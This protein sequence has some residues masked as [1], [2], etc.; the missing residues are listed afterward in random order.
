MYHLY[1]LIYNLLCY[2]IFSFSTVCSSSTNNTPDSPPSHTTYSPHI[3]NPRLHPH[4]IQQQTPLIPHHP[5]HP[6]QQQQLQQQQHHMLQQQQQHIL[7]YHRGQDFQQGNLFRKFA[8]PVGDIC[9]RG[10]YFRFWIEIDNIV[11]Y[12]IFAIK[13][14]LKNIEPISNI[15]FM[16]NLKR[17]LTFL[18]STRNYFLPFKKKS[19]LFWGFNLNRKVKTV[20]MPNEVAT[21]ALLAKQVF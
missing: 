5:H 2:C 13:M 16:M 6:H 3:P 18:L 1:V 11:Y 9:F 12:Y 14:H 21:R 19:N 8:E 20:I 15:F 10:R 4:H 7:G 17:K